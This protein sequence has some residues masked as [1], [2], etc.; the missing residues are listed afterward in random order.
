MKNQNERRFAWGRI[1]SIRVRKIEINL[2][3]V[4]FD[5][6]NE[7]WYF[8]DLKSWHLELRRF[9][10]NRTSSTSN[11]GNSEIQK[12]A[13]LDDLKYRELRNRKTC[14][15]QNLDLQFSISKTFNT[16]KFPRIAT[17]IRETCKILYT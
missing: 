2:T 3:Y 14:S 7:N 1:F 12:Y 5:I 15:F 11:F 16:L 13:D 9:E 8:G 10:S 4:G 6:C 17:R